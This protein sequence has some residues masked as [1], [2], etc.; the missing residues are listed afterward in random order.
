MST[1]KDV[2]ARAGVSIATVSYVMNNS[3][4]VK[5]ETRA[6]VLEAA[7]S[8]NYVPNASARNLK[9]SSSKSVGIVLP[10]IQD[11][12]YASIF[13]S[14]SMYLQSHDYIPRVAFSN[15]IPGQERRCIDELVSMNIDGLLLITCQPENTEFFQRH[16]ADTGVPVVFIER[17]PLSFPSNFIGFNSY[18][19]AYRLTSRLLQQG[20]RDILL[21]CGPLQFSPE[22]N[23]LQGY[24]DAFEAEGISGDQGAE[25]AADAAESPGNANIFSTVMNKEDAFRDFLDA[26]NGKI[27]EAIICTSRE[28][29]KG[30]SVAIRY[31]GYRVPD[32][33]L[34]ITFG[35]ESWNN[36][37]TN[38]GMLQISRPA[39][40][41]GDLAARTMIR[42]VEQPELTDLI[43][44]ELDDTTPEDAMQFPEA[45]FLRRYAL[46]GSHKAGSSRPLRILIVDITA[47]QPIMSL[48]RHFSD[49]TGIPVEYTICPQEELLEKMS[50][51]FDELTAN[52]D[53]YTYN[54]PWRDFMAENLCLA[55]LSEFLEQYEVNTDRFFP[56]TLENCKIGNRLYGI[57]F[58]ASAQILLYRN[59]FF[60]DPALQQ[61]FGKQNTISLRP[62]RTWTE[63]NNVAAFFTRSLNP[64][65]PSEYGTSFA[66]RSNEFLAP[67]LLIRLFS[68]GGAL[69]DTYNHPTFNT[70]ANE[71]ALTATLEQLRF[72][73]PDFYEKD[74][75]GT[76]DDFC[77]GRTAMLIAFGDHAHMISRRL[78]RT[79]QAQVGSFRI[80]GGKPIRGGFCFGVNPYSKMRQEAFAYLNWFCR[81]DTSFY[82]T[83]LNGAS[84]FMEPYHNYELQQLYPWLIWSEQSIAPS[85]TRNVPHRRRMQVIPSGSPEGILCDAFRAAESGEMSVKKAL[86]RAQAQ[87]ERLYREY[88]YPI[89]KTA[90]TSLP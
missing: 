47:T 56:E 65:S 4:P 75:D 42:C 33:L 30:I 83:V 13:N 38:A 80:P 90:P 71:R 63:Y 52:F 9:V 48:T 28:I 89:R 69:W 7:Q 27:P 70:P 10:N 66:A 5:P 34:L 37:H 8:L 18:R 54:A 12:L 64:D 72:V 26:Y 15:D 82:L 21:A 22:Q 31:G 57:P 50:H 87:A 77:S 85:V 45:S 61:A 1:I 40:Q 11:P 14:L 53:L 36:M 23:S 62:P 20:Y 55:E 60:N 2:A 84:P 79:V 51:S 73:P 46:P 59:D 41:L 74:I 17:A 19:A 81:R 25:G 49:Q 88:G 3:R 6:R 16:L 68:F 29:E 78:R 86:D 32:D 58:T 43:Y 39:M 76:I 35:E 24:Q 44:R 67:E